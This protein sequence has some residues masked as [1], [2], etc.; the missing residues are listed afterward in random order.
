MKTNKTKLIF[1]N[2]TPE[3][4][5]SNLESAIKSLQNIDEKDFSTENIKKTLM[6]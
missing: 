1:K 6:E 3:K 4:I 5:K 2:S